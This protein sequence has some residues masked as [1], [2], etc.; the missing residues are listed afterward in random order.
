MQNTK[1][2]GKISID[3]DFEA[4]LLPDNKLPIL[5]ETKELIKQEIINFMIDPEF[6]KEVLVENLIK[7]YPECKGKNINVIIK[8]GIDVPYELSDYFPYVEGK[9]YCVDDPSKKEIDITRGSVMGLRN[10]SLKTHLQYA[11]MLFQEKKMVESLNE[12]L[13]LCREEKK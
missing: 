9:A 4:T 11:I 3:I 6:L 7:R 5:D 12:L 1:D 13:D 10:K 2:V 8:Y